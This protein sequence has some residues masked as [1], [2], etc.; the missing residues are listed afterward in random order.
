MAMKLADMQAQLAALSAER[1]VLDKAIEDMIA[2]MADVPADQRKS[3]EWAPNGALTK[4]YL[5]LSNRQAEIEAEIVELSR[6]IMNSDEPPS[7][8]H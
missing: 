5:E 6:G 2:D 8:V 1:D 3:G 4:K 7:S